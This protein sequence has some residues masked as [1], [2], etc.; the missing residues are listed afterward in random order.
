M[1]SKDRVSSTKNS[2]TN[3]CG[4]QGWRPI[5]WWSDQSLVE[6]RWEFPGVRKHVGREKSA[7]DSIT[8]LCVRACVHVWPQCHSD[9][10]ESWNLQGLCLE[11]QAPCFMVRGP[12]SSQV[13]SYQV[14]GEPAGALALLTWKH[15][16]A[17]VRLCSCWNLCLNIPSILAMLWVIC[18]FCEAAAVSHSRWERSL[19]WYHS[20]PISDLL[21]CI[22]G[23]VITNLSL[24]LFHTP[25]IFFPARQMSNSWRTAG[26]VFV[27][28]SALMLVVFIQ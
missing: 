16:H 13:C 10:W 15:N 17:K 9:C 4:E 23:L 12:G 2:W 7:A 21:E 5:Q 20:V 22:P 28:L 1:C 26:N 19:L 24:L 18:P 27:S 3:F 8:V 11:H 6:P 25:G 14:L